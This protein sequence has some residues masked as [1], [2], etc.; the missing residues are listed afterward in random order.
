MRWTV[1]V[2]VIIAFFDKIT[3]DVESAQFYLLSAIMFV[4]ME[5][6]DNTKVRR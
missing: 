5:I 3:G 4:L 2:F 1:L 6:A